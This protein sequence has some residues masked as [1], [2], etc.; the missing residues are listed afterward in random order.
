MQ[1]VGKQKVD[2]VSKKSGQPVRGLTLHVVGIHNDVEGKAVE[3][4]FVSERS[5]IFK[6]VAE[7]PLGTEIRCSYNRWGNI[8]SV[9]EVKK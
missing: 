6:G 4:L 3:T 8:E 1:I 7:M 2:Y 9:V 5:E